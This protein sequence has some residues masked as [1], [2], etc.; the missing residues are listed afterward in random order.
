ME[1]LPFKLKKKKIITACSG[2]Y[3]ISGNKVE[4][5]GFCPSSREKF[6]WEI[7]SIGPDEFKAVHVSFGPQL[8]EEGV[9]AEKVFKRLAK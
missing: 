8:P 4:F 7:I 5:E 1:L 2:K 6:R 3:T 9:R